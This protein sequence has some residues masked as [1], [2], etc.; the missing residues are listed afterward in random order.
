MSK[1]FELSPE[2][3]ERMRSRGRRTYDRPAEDEIEAMEA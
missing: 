2:E 1:S 3:I